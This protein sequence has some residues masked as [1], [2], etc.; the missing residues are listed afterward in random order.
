MACGNP[1]N[2]LKPVQLGL[3]SH[4]D[5]ASSSA[6]IAIVARQYRATNVVELH[7]VEQRGTTWRV[8]QL[9]HHVHTV[10]IVGYHDATLLPRQ[11]RRD[12]IKY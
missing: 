3:L 10:S 2:V 7:G 9:S 11:S 5:Y 12:Q 4:P 6:V 1:I 8:Y